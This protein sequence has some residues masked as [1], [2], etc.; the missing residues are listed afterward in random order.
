MSLPGQSRTV[1]QTTWSS[2]V[3]G[4]LVVNPFTPLSFR[5]TTCHVDPTTGDICLKEDSIDE[6]GELSQEPLKLNKRDKGLTKDVYMVCAP[7]T[8]PQL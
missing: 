8:G 2:N 4:R 7:Y 6:T 3:I 5:R 1:L